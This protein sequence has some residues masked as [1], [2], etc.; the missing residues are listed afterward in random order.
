MAPLPPDRA[1]A[2]LRRYHRDGCPQARRRLIE[3]HLPLV[4]AVARRFAM[5]GEP[6]EDL[7]QEGCIGLINAVD[8]FDPA[9]ELPFEAFAVPTIAGAI[10]RHLRD[11]CATVR[12]PRELI[13]QRT[14]VL[15]MR[16]ALEARRGRP[17]TLSELAGATRL[18]PAIVAAA[19]TTTRVEPLDEELAYAP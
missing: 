3:A 8:R 11:R 7:V 14:T 12:L 13:E 2:L 4:R 5:H 17:V 6:L 15:R 16:T 19:L 9:R 10:R 1:A 18:P